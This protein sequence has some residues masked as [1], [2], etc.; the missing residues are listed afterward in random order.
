MILM[1]RFIP[2]LLVQ[3]K[4]LYKGRN[5]KNLRYVGDPINAVKIF[6]DK[7]VDEILILDIGVT[8]SSSQPDLEFIREMAGEAF[9][10]LAYGGGITTIDQVKSIIDQGVEKIVI[11]TAAFF[12]PDLISQCAKIIGSSSTVISVDYKKMLLKGNRVFVNNGTIDTKTDVITYVKKMEDLGAGEIILNSIDREG[13]Y[14][15]YDTDL[16][17]SVSKSLKI[18]LIAS[19]GAASLTDLEAA[20]NVGASA[21][22]AGSMFVFHGKHK[23]VLITYPIK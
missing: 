5:F 18:P 8:N 14:Q 16:I 10:P 4:L 15:G 3:N 23:A 20:I 11:N 22:A 17:S 12:N 21:S 9:M 6:N 2:V 13:T 1:N 7:E 19:G